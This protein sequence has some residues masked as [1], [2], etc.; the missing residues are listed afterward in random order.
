M[1]TPLF[2]FDGGEA[3]TMPACLCLC[4]RVRVRVEGRGE[5]RGRVLGFA[6]GRGHGRFVCAVPGDTCVPGANEAAEAFDGKFQK[7]ADRRV[8]IGLQSRG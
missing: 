1:D 6:D 3:L 4:V 5:R 8:R 2:L 7:A